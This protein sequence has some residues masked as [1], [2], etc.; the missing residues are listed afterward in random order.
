[1]KKKSNRLKEVQV[2]T[3]CP[4]GV[5]QVDV[6]YWQVKW[7]EFAEAGI[8]VVKKG[9]LRKVLLLHRIILDECRCN[10]E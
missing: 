5:H 4:C 6:V 1:M 8:I 7:K 10:E 9:R 2:H 3:E